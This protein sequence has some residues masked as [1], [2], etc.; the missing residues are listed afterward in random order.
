V[1][2]FQTPV[3]SG[4]KTHGN[5]EVQP[6]NCYSRMGYRISPAEL[7]CFHTNYLIPPE[8]STKLSFS[9]TSL[10]TAP[11]DIFVD[12]PYEGNWTRC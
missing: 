7:L 6:Y 5:V 10:F 4:L 3:K 11:H 2:D 9:Q 12:K 8:Q 1:K